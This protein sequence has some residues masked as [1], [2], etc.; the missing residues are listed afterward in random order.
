MGMELVLGTW[1]EGDSYY[2]ERST[3]QCHFL[4]LYPGIALLKR[5]LFEEVDTMMDDGIMMCC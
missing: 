1:L 4:P 2:L 5:F 3:D